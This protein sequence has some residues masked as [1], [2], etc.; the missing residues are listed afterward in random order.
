[1]DL[2]S[3]HILYNQGR[4]WVIFVGFVLVLFVLF[5]FKFLNSY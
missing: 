2:V 1:M 3:H 4:S 5:H